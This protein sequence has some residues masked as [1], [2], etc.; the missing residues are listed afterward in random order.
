L[1]LAALGVVIVVVGVD[2][3]GVYWGGEASGDGGKNKTAA[4]GSSVGPSDSGSSLPT[5]SDSSKKDDGSPGPT[6]SAPEAP[7]AFAARIQ[8][9]EDRG[10]SCA[11]DTSKC[12]GAY[13]YSSPY[14]GG[15]Q[16]AG[17][18]LTEGRS[19]TVTCAIT[20]GRHLKYEVGTAYRGP[21]PPPY[22]TWLKLD[23]GKWATAV[24]VEFFNGVKLTD[25][26]T[27]A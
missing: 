8:Y 1:A 24:Y 22:T 5:D 27:C 13:L 16:T 14:E 17:E 21:K 12:R 9:T 15:E 20:N 3:G 11:D 23:I 19:I 26:P 4:H 25:L 18:H 6:Q 10:P 7:K 2:V